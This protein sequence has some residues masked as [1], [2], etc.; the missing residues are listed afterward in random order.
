MRA[1]VPARPNPRLAV[2]T[3][4]L[5]S[6]AMLLV[7][8]PEP[9][10][11]LQERGRV[12]RVL[13]GDTVDVD[14]DGD[15][16]ADEQV[17]LVGLDTPEKNQCGYSVAQ[18]KLKRLVEGRVVTLVTDNSEA[19]ATQGRILR[20]VV[21]KR[22]GKRIDAT[23]WMLRRGLGLW[24]P[25]PEEPS[26]M[27]RY[28]FLT[29]VAAEDGRNLFAGDWCSAGPAAGVRLRL[30]LQW[31]A[32]TNRGEHIRITNLGPGEVD[33]SDWMIRS[34]RVRKYRV[35]KGGAIAEGRTLTIHVGSGTNGHYHRYLGSGRSL[36]PDI[37]VLDP[38]AGYPG[39][40]AYLLDPGGDVRAHQLYPCV[41]ACAHAANGK[42]K[43]TEVNY[44]PPG[45]DKDKLNEEWF[46]VTNV[47]DRTVHVG[48]LVLDAHPYT[49]ELPPHKRLAPNERIIVRSGSG[50]STSSEYFLN[51]SY[52]VLNNGGETVMVRTY[53]GVIIDEYSWG[54]AMGSTSSGD[55]GTL[56][57]D[58]A[59]VGTPL[60]GDWDG[61]GKA[62]PGW[63]LGGRFVLSNELDGAPAMAFDFGRG[64]DVPLAGDWNG[65]GTDTV[66]VVRDGTWHLINSHRG[67]SSDISFIYGRVTRGDIPLIG[68]WNGD[69]QDEIGIVR[70]GEWHLRRSLSGGPGEIR[71]TYGRVTRGDVPLIGDWDGDGKDTVGIVRDGEWHLRK[72]LSGGPGEI[73]FTYGRVSKGDV[74]VVSDLN[75][76]GA[77]TPTVVRSYTWYHREH[78]SGGPADLTFYWAP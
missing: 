45:N 31:K 11:A 44:D 22:D 21:V 54:D 19:F 2:T 77:D 66:G 57:P 20:R 36:F 18:R 72:S 64:Q 41:H 38:L 24:K 43:I 58:T 25:Y 59:F 8:A 28:R 32:D 29:S 35:P 1:A 13:D 17:R 27:P 30:D 50:K 53:P 4:V 46:E 16:A 62:T 73:R 3:V 9:A 6:L 10:S 26:A 69:G 70:D 5:M 37:D 40:G 12:T 23:A 15:G 67:G 68:D 39:E 56:S 52:P 14:L 33:L 61:D 63:F 34:G 47:S 76:D 71:F 65:D 51:S 49:V 48:R 75:R 78:L 55:G 7:Q 60:M 74:P 42:I